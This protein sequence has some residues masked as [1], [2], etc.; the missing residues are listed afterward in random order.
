M[1]K[2][3]LCICKNKGV[4]QLRSNHP[5]E[6]RPCFSFI[7]TCSTIPLLPKSSKVVTSTA[8]FISGQKSWKGFSC[9]CSFNPSLLYGKPFYYL[10]GNV[11]ILFIYKISYKV[12]KISNIYQISY[13][14]Y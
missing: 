3:A 9:C 8:W 10:L 11:D 13:I 12:Y 5:A 6:Q 2:P 7:D 1:R 14:L 4:D